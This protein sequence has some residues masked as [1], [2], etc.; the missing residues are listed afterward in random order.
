MKKKISSILVGLI[1]LSV[2]NGC[3]GNGGNGGNG[4]SEESN[5]PYLKSNHNNYSKLT[6]E[7]NPAPIKN[8][9]ALSLSWS[10]KSKTETDAI[11]LY[12]H[13]NFMVNTLEN[14]GNPQPW[15]KL[16]LLEAFMKIAKRYTTEINRVDNINVLVTKTATD[17]CAYKVISAHSD[18][19]SGDFFGQGVTSND[20]SSTAEEI[21]NSTDCSASKID[22]ETYITANQKTRGQ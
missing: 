12:D 10:I 11:K 21:I 16:F 7:A 18:V 9:T 2:I 15:D 14:G 1:A 20:H 8:E 22:L 13:I 5:I 4:P 19:V 6:S 3:G 17:R